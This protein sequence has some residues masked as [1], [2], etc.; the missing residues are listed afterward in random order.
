M[1]D[2]R[3]YFF[4]GPDR[5]VRT[6]EFEAEND[7]AAIAAVRETAYSV[8]VELWCDARWVRSFPKPVEATPDAVAVQGLA[9]GM[10]EAERRV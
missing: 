2:Y 4:E 6:K 7:S 3:L 9:A 5:I 1:R 10:G 8:A